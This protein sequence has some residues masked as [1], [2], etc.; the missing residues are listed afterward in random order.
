MSAGHRQDKRG[1]IKSTQDVDRTLW[2][3][4]LIKSECAGGVMG[5]SQLHSWGGG[6][7]E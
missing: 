3:L 4:V 1:S 2:Y 5:L 6:W 7:R